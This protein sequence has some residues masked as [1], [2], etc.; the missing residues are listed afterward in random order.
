MHVNKLHQFTERADPSINIE[1]VI[2]AQFIC[3]EP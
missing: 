2:E 1:N 3:W